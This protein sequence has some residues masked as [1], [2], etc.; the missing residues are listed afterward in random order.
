MKKKLCADKNV[1]FLCILEWR[2]NYKQ[3]KRTEKNCV[4][5]EMKKKNCLQII[6]SKELWAD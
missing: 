4:Q 5:I 1:E 2:K 3:L 6:N